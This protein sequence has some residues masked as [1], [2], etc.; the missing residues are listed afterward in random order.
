MRVDQF[1]MRF[2][3][4]AGDNCQLVPMIRGRKLKKLQGE[5]E[6]GETYDDFLNLRFMEEADKDE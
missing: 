3:E 5:D 1:I 6:E 4:A 2:K